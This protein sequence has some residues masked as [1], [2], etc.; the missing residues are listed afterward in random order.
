MRTL[1]TASPHRH[2][3]RRIL[4]AKPYGAILVTAEMH[5]ATFRNFTA[6]AEAVIEEDMKDVSLF[7]TW[8]PRSL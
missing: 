6:A 2:L 4:L 8:L 7:Q 3:V 5:N 1:G